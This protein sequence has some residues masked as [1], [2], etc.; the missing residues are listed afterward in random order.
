PLLQ[1]V[2]D[3]LSG[4]PA[5]RSDEWSAFEQIGAR[6]VECPVDL[7]KRDKLQNRKDGLGG[8]PI[9]NRQGAQRGIGDVGWAATCQRLHRGAYRLDQPRR[10]VRP[11]L[12]VFY[13]RTRA[14]GT[15]GE[16]Q[17]P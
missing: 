3:E 10:E 13:V 14:T 12:G 6:H 17:S 2:E 11:R 1:V 4:S 7:A 16:D 9:E 5:K 15:A 8:P